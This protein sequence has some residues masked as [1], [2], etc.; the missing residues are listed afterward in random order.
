MNDPQ[1]CAAINDEQT[2]CGASFGDTS[3]CRVLLS[4]NLAVGVPFSEY[5]DAGNGMSL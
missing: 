5:I 2:G 4:A 1:N 3:T